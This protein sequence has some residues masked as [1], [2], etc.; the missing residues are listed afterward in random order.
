M[1]PS[2]PQGPPHSPQDD[3]KE[4][5]QSSG[6]SGP[7]PSTGEA[8]SMRARCFV[9]EGDP[10]A[11]VRCTRPAPTFRVVRGARFYRR[12][13]EQATNPPI[14]RPRENHQDASREHFCV[15][16]PGLWEA[17]SGPWGQGGPRVERCSEGSTGWPGSPLPAVLAFRR[18][19]RSGLPF[20]THTIPF[21]R[22]GAERSIQWNVLPCQL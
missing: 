9:A 19:P 10:R 3:H 5:S 20:T 14:A 16:W 6:V 13:L 12:G 7:G 15:H 8:V 2:F 4:T 22:E 17:N 1:A 21:A 18:R 11:C